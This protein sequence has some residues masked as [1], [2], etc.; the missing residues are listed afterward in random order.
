M[1]RS[2]RVK[3]KLMHFLNL[4]ELNNLANVMKR[5]SSTFSNILRLL[6]S[7][8]DTHQIAL[9]FILTKHARFKLQHLVR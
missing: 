1:C 2:I 4:E 3:Y 8:F 5:L 9:V 7:L 6:Y